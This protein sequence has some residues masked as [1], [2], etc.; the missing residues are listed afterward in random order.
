MTRSTPGLATA[1]A[2]SMLVIVACGRVERAA[3]AWPL[4]PYRP[5]GVHPRGRGGC[6]AGRA[7]HGGPPRPPPPPPCLGGFLA[8]PARARAPFRGEEGVPGPGPA[9]RR[10]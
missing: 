6:R 8:P 9:D 3:T 7:V 5:P 1:A 10:R 4:R 2:L